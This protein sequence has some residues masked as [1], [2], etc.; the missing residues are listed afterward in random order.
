MDLAALDK[1][2]IGV[3]ATKFGI[4]LYQSLDFEHVHTFA[5]DVEVTVQLMRY[6]RAIT[7]EDQNIPDKR[8]QT[9]ANDD[10]SDQELT[11]ICQSLSLVSLS[12]KEYSQDR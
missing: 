7:R 10:G 11:E 6:S 9:V 2:V 5:V 8:Q 3:A 12:S 1:A 4:S